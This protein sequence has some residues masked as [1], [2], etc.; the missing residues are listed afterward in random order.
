M[1]EVAKKCIEIP[2]KPGIM[3]SSEVY[4]YFVWLVPKGKL[5][6]EDM[7]HK[8]IAKTLKCAWIGFNSPVLKYLTKTEFAMKLIDLVPYHRIVSTR[9]YVYNPIYIEELKKEGFIIENSKG[10]RGLRVKDYKKC[11]FNYD[12]VEDLDE[13]L[14]MQIQNEGIEHFVPLDLNE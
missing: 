1:N 8:Y 11:M 13:N 7:I 5:T 3:L 9:G 10:N 14:I 6:T 2:A 4:D 12:E